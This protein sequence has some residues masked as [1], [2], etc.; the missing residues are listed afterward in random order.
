MGDWLW[1]QCVV[2]WGQICL[3]TEGSAGAHYRQHQPP[4]FPCRSSLTSPLLAEGEEK[5]RRGGR[6]QALAV[7]SCIDV[8]CPDEGK[9]STHEGKHSTDVGKHST[10]E[11]KHSTDEGKHST[12]EGKYSTDEGKHST[13]HFKICY[14]WCLK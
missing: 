11:G 10:H 1:H 7:R 5:E 4:L 14:C 2:G 13:Q 3:P 12:D 6:Y 8:Y 9:H